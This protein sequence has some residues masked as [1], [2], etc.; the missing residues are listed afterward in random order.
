M[1][2]ISTR[3][4]EE[5]EKQRAQRDADRQLLKSVGEKIADDRQLLK[6][7]DEKIAKKRSEDASA[8]AKRKAVAKKAAKITLV[9]IL[10]SSCLCFFSPSVGI[11]SAVVFSTIPSLINLIDD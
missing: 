5:E 11:F 4:K 9:G 7:V 8:E 3:Q 6:S 2:I 1:P 10:L